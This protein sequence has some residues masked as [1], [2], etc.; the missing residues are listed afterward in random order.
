MQGLF[1]YGFVMETQFYILLSLKATKGFVHYGQYFFGYDL[2]A[3]YNLFDQMNG[4]REIRGTALLHIDL[5]ET[6]DELLVK[7]KT[8][9]CTLDELCESLFKRGGNKIRV[10]GSCIGHLWQPENFSTYHFRK[11]VNYKV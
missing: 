7:I 11:L 9:C 3:A 1:C 6:V 10:N 8:V 5:M 2:E 4:S